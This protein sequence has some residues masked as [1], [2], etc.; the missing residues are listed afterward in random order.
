MSSTSTIQHFPVDMILMQITRVTV[1]VT[2]SYPG[3]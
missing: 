1:V 2:S 3:I